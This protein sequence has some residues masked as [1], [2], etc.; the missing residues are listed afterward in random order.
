MQQN[1]YPQK[2]LIIFLMGPTAS[3]KTDLALKLFD[4]FACELISVDSALIYRDMN[5]GTAKPAKTILEKYPHNL[6]DILDPSEAY[7]TGQF[8]EDALQLIEKS[9]EK[10]RI[11]LLVGGTMLYFRTL[12][13]GISPLPSANIPIRDQINARA[14]EIGWAELHNELA[15]IDPVAAKRIHPNDPQRI[16]RAL[17]VFQITGKT[18]TQLHAQGKQDLQNYKILALAMNPIERKDLHKRIEKRFLQMLDAGF[19][20]E[21]KALHQRSDLHLGLPAIRAVGYRQVW[22][23]LEGKYSYDEMVAKAI[24]ATRQLAKRQI[25]WLRSWEDLHWLDSEDPQLLAK[26][27]AL[28]KDSR[29]E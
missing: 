13:Q 3:G 15:K 11:P 27:Q 17:E 14:A 28:I 5:I 19:I 20:D 10:K 24:A 22:E 23:Y 4:L 21:V 29:E 8:R 6:I 12:L 1:S 26:V 16:S 7:S 18:L 2:N 9:L 25:T